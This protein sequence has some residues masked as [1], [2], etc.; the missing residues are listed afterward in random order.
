L[1]ALA[2]ETGT[3]LLLSCGVM[4]EIVFSRVAKRFGAYT[5]IPDLSFKIEEG[6]FITLLGPSGC[7]K[8]TTLRMV[9][10][11][12]L[13]DQGHI[14][15]GGR[16]VTKVRPEHRRI[17]MVFQD[18]AL[19][20]HLTVRENIIFGLRERRVPAGQWQKR[21]DELL[22]LVRLSEH[23]E[24]FPHQLSGGQRQRVALAR[25]LAFP[26]EVL[27]MDEPLGALDLKLRQT[28]QLEII[29]IQRELR[30]T[31]LYVTH[32]QEEALNLSDRIA[33]MDRGEIVQVGTGTS[34]YDKPSTPFVADFLGRV[35]FL[36]G[37]VRSRTANGGA[38]V[39]CGSVTLHGPELDAPE[40]APVCLG[41]RPERLHLVKE[42]SSN[43]AN[44]MSGQIESMTF[45]GNL[46]RYY[47]RCSGCGDE[48]VMMVEQ[49]ERKSMPARGQSVW[50][51]WDPDAIMAWPQQKTPS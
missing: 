19:F 45:A 49:Q 41:I 22:A 16:D 36:H 30:I 18:Y 38:I 8:T 34:I 11:L 39:E 43:P 5:A 2:T 15:I 47:V 37:R 13:P 9:A 6:E 31:T 25:A 3:F 32:D 12:E 17:G 1:H 46:V 29:R 35:N 20:P 40:G 14:F 48:V 26:P 4:A 24:K 33:V 28:M 50:L 23:V 27:L 51:E 10:G 44:G 7:G 21:V 42:P